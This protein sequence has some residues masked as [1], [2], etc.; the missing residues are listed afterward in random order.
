M[1]RICVFSAAPPVSDEECSFHAME[2]GSI[3]G[4]ILK[5]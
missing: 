2:Y 1:E 5:Q 4:I 3:L